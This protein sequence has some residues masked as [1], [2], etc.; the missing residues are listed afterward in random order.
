MKKIFLF[1]LLLLIIPIASA[2]VGDTFWIDALGN[3]IQGNRITINNGE[4]PGFHTYMF[5]N[6]PYDIYVYM[7]DVSNLNNPSNVH[8]F[9]FAEDYDERTFIH[10][11]IIESDYY[12]PGKDYE[13]QIT[14]DSG[15]EDALYREILYLEVRPEQENHEPTI[16]LISPGDE[17]ADVEIN[18]ALTWRG[19]DQDN[20]QLTYDV[21]LNND[22][23]A[24]NINDMRYELENLNYDTVYSW[25]VFASDGFSEA[26]SE[27]WAFRTIQRGSENNPPN[28]PSRPYPENNAEN[29]PTELTLR[30]TGGDP[31][32][33]AVT[34]DVYLNNI[35]KCDDARQTSCYI[36]DLDYDTQYAWKISAS[37]G[38][39]TTDGPVWRFRTRNAGGSTHPP[40][41]EIINPRENSITRRDYNIQW[42]SNDIDGNVVNTRIY[43][44][45]L[46]NIP[47]I[48]KIIDI[49]NEYTL[50]AE[51]EGNIQNYQWNTN[52]AIDGFYSIKIVVTDDDNLSGE[53]SVEMFKIVNSPPRINHAPAIISE[54]VTRAVVN[55]E[56][57]YD[58]NAVDADDNDISYNLIRLPDGMIID[59][60]T[61]IIKWTPLD[62]GQFIVTVEARD[63]VESFDLQTF[64][65]TVSL[66]GG[67]PEVE[68]KKIHKFS[69]SNVILDYDGNFI[70]VYAKIDNNGNQDE[71]I[72]L[73]AINMNTGEMTYDSFLIENGDG[74]WRILRLSR[75]NINGV[76]TIGIYGSSKNYKDMLYRDIVI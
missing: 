45:R 16:E 55:A 57:L 68:I 61:G 43:Y 26:R 28:I 8:T 76:Y 54:P 73:K 51:F 71:R 46:Q 29:M 5:S 27:T 14:G 67:V 53:D 70:N 75:P 74:Y 62:I 31:D 39:S 17:Q 20:D 19:S 11:Y 49:F 38:Q 7:I 50:L 48:G 34:Y 25:H 12:Q 3:E 59:Q 32:N 56:Y 4:E 13:V 69:V 47:L 24:D 23:K 21:Y 30:W 15:F 35:L 40:T 60:N 33:D 42:A 63:W 2:V 58:V 66:N 44:K 18:P 64:L 1:S 6:I 41:I 22:L 9:I 72:Q 65:I 10:D 36:E 37:D 52:N